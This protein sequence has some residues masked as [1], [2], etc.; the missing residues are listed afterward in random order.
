MFAARIQNPVEVML[1]GTLPVAASRQ[2][3]AASTTSG[4]VK[5]CT[6]RSS[7]RQLKVWKPLDD[8]IRQ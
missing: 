1:L 4:A 7:Q 2:A 5:P 8:D 6:R 3:V